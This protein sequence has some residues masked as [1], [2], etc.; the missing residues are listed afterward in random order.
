MSL[1]RLQ[2]DASLVRPWFLGFEQIRVQ[3]TLHCSRSRVRPVWYLRIPSVS[4][5]PLCLVGTNRLSWRLHG[6]PCLWCFVFTAIIAFKPVPFPPL[7]ALAA[8]AALAAAATAGAG[9]SL[10]TAAEFVATY[11]RVV[12]ATVVVLTTS[13]DTLAF[14][15]TPFVTPIVLTLPSASTAMIL[16]PFPARQASM[17]GVTSHARCSNHWSLSYC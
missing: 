15:F 9:A 6:P 4:P 16:I 17:L 2:V 12:A 14:I 11:V 13:T 7:V 1:A 3:A 5:L 10:T 8:D